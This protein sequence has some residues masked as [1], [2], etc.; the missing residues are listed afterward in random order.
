MEI[1]IVDDNQIARELLHH[2]LTSHGYEVVS[3]RDGQEALDL[4]HDRDCQIVITDWMM[5]RMTGLELCHKIREA[6][7]SRYHL[8][9]PRH[10]P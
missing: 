5:P 2:T 8:R 4:L 7:F 3:A 9:D 1:L 10:P 6:Q